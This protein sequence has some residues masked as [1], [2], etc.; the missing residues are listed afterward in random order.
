MS[1]NKNSAVRDHLSARR[2]KIVFP[3][4][5][6]TEPDATGYSGDGPGD[7]LIAGQMTAGQTISSTTT[8]ITPIGVLFNS[9]GPLNMPAVRKSQA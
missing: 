7:P 5:P 2:R 6:D 4:A 1:L 8:S 9:D 3:F